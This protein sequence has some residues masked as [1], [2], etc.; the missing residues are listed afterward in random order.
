ME[1]D[2]EAKPIQMLAEGLGKVE[3]AIAGSDENV[4]WHPFN[5]KH[6]LKSILLPK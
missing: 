6:L 1:G 4:H 3:E 2:D 5:K